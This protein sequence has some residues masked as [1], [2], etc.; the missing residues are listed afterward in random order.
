MVAGSM[1]NLNIELRVAK[2][3]RLLVVGKAVL[4]RLWGTVERVSP[5]API[6]VLHLTCSE[7]GPRQRPI[8]CCQRS[9]PG[10]RS[11]LAQRSWG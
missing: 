7:E 11:A 9:G 2:P 6:P 5:E 3:P 10:W 8:R 4:D 1:N